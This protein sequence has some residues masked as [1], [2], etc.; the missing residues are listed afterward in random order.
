MPRS[1]GGIPIARMILGRN[2]ACIV[3]LG[4]TSSKQLRIWFMHTFCAR[5]VRIYLISVH[6]LY[7]NSILLAFHAVTYLLNCSNFSSVQRSS[8][9][10]VSTASFHAGQTSSV[11][12]YWLGFLR[13]F[14]FARFR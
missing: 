14:S 4:A 7:E 5:P 2:S 11:D 10:I 6:W 12:L 13:N 9:R 3:G 1:G 8:Y